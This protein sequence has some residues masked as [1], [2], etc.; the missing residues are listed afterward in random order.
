MASIAVISIASFSNSYATKQTPP[1][2]NLCASEQSRESGR[3][4][5]MRSVVAQIETMD[6][7]IEHGAFIVND[8]GTYKALKIVSGTKDGILLTEYTK[9]LTAALYGLD[10]VVGMVHSHPLSLKTFPGQADLENRLNRAPSGNDFNAIAN[11][12]D[13][14]KASLKFFLTASGGD[15]NVWKQNFAHYIISPAAELA[16]F[17]NEVRLS[18]SIVRYGAV[19]YKDTYYSTEIFDGGTFSVISKLWHSFV[20]SDAASHC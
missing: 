8:N 10:E 19:Y 20:K 6:Q 13:Q 15:Y 17:D 2:Q 18:G 5:A 16:E 11:D 1:G 7:T 3:D 9:S 12:A 4:A 14:T